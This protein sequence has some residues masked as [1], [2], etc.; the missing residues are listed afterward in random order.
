M[1]ATLSP[2]DRDTKAELNHRSQACEG[3]DR[4]RCSRRV[5]W[6]EC[7]RMHQVP[8]PLAPAPEAGALRATTC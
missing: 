1:L 8:P 7:W 5:K 2:E 6:S 3:P 4:H